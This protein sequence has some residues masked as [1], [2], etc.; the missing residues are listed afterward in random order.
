MMGAGPLFASSIFD[1]QVGAPSTPSHRHT[2][3]PLSESEPLNNPLL[4][5]LSRLHANIDP[6]LGVF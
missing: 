4:N 2:V 1:D 3:P 6:I 5:A